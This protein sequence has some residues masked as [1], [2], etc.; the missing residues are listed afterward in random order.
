[1][2]ADRS[3][4]KYTKPFKL[5]EGKKTVKAIAISRFVYK[6]IKNALQSA[7]YVTSFFIILVDRDGTR[8][9]HVVSKGFDVEFPDNYDEHEITR[10]ITKKNDYEFIDEIEKER[11]KVN[12]NL[13]IVCLTSLFKLSRQLK[14]GNYS[15]TRY[16]EEDR[17]YQQHE[18]VQK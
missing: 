12:I 18:L 17:R 5:R 16:L 8:E 6:Y 9:S 2:G 1:V 13:T 15:Q 14:I 4:I 10:T 3:T 7:Y 11:K